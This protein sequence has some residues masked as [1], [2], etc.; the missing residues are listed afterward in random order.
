M[1]LLTII[2]NG[3]EYTVHAADCKDLEKVSH[4]EQWTA[5]YRDQDAF[6]E[7]WWGDAAEERFQ[8]YSEFWRLLI[9]E[10][11]DINTAIKPCVKF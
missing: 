1:A 3:G 8:R 5:E 7:S 4:L 6:A 9:D 2:D 10:Y 11:M